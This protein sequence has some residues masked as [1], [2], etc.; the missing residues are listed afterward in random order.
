MLTRTSTGSPTTP[1]TL[2][3]SCSRPLCH[4]ARSLSK[5]KKLKDDYD[6]PPE[7]KKKGKG[8]KS[9][10][11]AVVVDDGDDMDDLM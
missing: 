5:K 8:K 4:R 10:K 11:K 9:K 3:L 7:D 6:S 1:S 2:A